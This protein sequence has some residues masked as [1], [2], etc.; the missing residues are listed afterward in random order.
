LFWVWLVAL[1]FSQALL[2]KKLS[3]GWRLALGIL[4]LATFYVGFVQT[5]RWKSGWVPAL[6]TIIAICGFYYWRLS[7][8]IMPF[9][10]IAAVSMATYLIATDQYSWGTRVDAW[11]IVMEIT[12]VNPLLGLGFGNYRWYA[13]LFPIRGYAVQFNSHSQYVDIIAQTGLVGFVCFLWLIAAIGWLGWR[14]RSHAPKGFATAYVYGALGGL[15]GTLTAG[16]LGDWVM[17]FFYN[18]GLSGFRSSVLAW[19]FL[20]GLAVIAN[21]YVSKRTLPSVE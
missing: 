7:L 16:F 17:P 20:G 12:K 15:V 8:F 21:L 4:V 19:L 6:V 13:P 9:A 11:I 3:L 2:N 18:V 10:A 14:V 5:E 1:A